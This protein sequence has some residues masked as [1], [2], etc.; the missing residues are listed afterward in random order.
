MNSFHHSVVKENIIVAEGEEAKHHLGSKL[1]LVIKKKEH[2]IHIE[3]NQTGF[4]SR[5]T[6]VPNDQASERAID[7]AYIINMKLAS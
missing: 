5:G 3:A 2:L 6:K 1:R 4:C 7:G